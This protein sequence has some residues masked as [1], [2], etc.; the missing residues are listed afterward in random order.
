MKDDQA[1]LAAICWRNVL[2]RI[3]FKLSEGL[4]IVVTGKITAYA[5]QSK[6]QISVDA[7][8]P[9]G[10][11]AFMQILTERKL[12]FQKEGL[13][14][15]EHKKPI[16]LLPKKIG[17]VT[18]MTGAVIRDIIHRIEDR[19]KTHIVIWPV[20]VQGNSSAQEVTEAIKGFNQFS[21][22]DKPD[23]LIVARG[24]G[25]IEDLW[26]F[27][28]EIVVR[29]AFESVIPI[30][31]AIGHE[32]DYSLLDLVADLR[33]PTPTA[34][35]EFAVPVA[36]DLLYTVN[37][38][39]K[40]MLSRLQESIKYYEQQIV[41]NTNHIHNHITNTTRFYIQRFDEI[42]LRF[43]KVLPDFIQQKLFRLKEFGLSVNT[44]YKILQYKKLQSNGIAGNLS[45]QKD[46]LFSSLEHQLQICTS[47]L[48][49]LD[50]QKVIR[51]GY[52]MIIDQN[53]HVISDIKK[54][55][56]QES[57]WLK[58]RDGQKKIRRE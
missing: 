31:S 49:S 52:A 44:V 35:A 38:L 26:S 53:D 37:N 27:N 33:A 16:P 10:I 47:M 15:K 9:S 2:S 50:Y 14:A 29:A 56:Q 28:E 17:I 30:I 39:E 3:N 57:F 46:K 12:K 23:L 42:L 40:I 45:A 43:N 22:Q 5:G 25:S 18:S 11:G 20:S 19:Y 21:E 48:S 51:R 58:M 6:Y 41:L 36:R 13:F 7:I 34:A 55:P 1:V 54:I 32:T 24:G 8:R 4:E